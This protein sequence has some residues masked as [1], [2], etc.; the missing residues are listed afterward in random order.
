MGTFKLPSITT[1]N[2]TGLVLGERELVYDTDLDAVYSGDG[3]TAGGVLVGGGVGDGDKGD[4]TVSGA[5]TV[6]TVDAGAITLSKMANLAASTI[7]GNNTGGAAAP[8]ALTSAQVKTLLA[9]AASDVSGLATIATSGSATDLGSGTLPAARFNDTAHGNRAGGSLHADVIAAGA[10]GFM[11]GADKTKLDGI[12]SGATVN[13]AD[14]ALRDRATHTGTQLSSTI[15]DFDTAVAATA[16]V[17]A[18]TAKVTNATHTGDV[19]GATALTISADA[20]TYA[21]MQDVSAASRLLGRGGSGPGDPQE[22]TLGAGLTMTGTTLAASGGGGSPGGATGEIQFNNAGALGGAADVE[23]EGGQLR[24][25]VI[26]PPTAPAADGLKMFAR[27]VGGRILPA[28]MGPSGLDSPLQPHLGLNKTAWAVPNGN[29]TVLSVSG[30]ALSAQGT[31][32]AKNWASTSRYTKMRGLEYLVTTAATTAIAAWRGGAAQ[33]TVGSNA[34]GD[35]GF[36]YI[37][38]WAPATGVAT[39]TTRAFCG[40]R[41]RVAAGTDQNPSGLLDLCG[42]GWDDADTNIQF[43]HND[44]SG[45]ATKIDLGASFP[46]PTTDR[47]NIYEVAM[48]SPPGVTQSVTYRV[49]NLVTGAEATG[50]VT[51]NLPA[52]TTALNPYAYFSVGGTLSVI[53]I[54]LFSLYVETDY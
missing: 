47:D 13:A 32:T 46:V 27:N 3:T 49:R 35:G 54:C 42:M 16:S 24:L 10:S 38:R 50:T 8:I 17:T 25:P 11:S 36:H 34:T 9:I 2:R 26:S 1:A 45:V 44:S 28:T 15:S 52:T 48:F 53:G 7:L 21:K 29:S 22:I 23:I 33:Y 51:T 18:N 37:C 12:A 40:L 41:E 20:V 39:T 31:A 43:I 4:I 19:T 5:G 14:S 6:W 30:V